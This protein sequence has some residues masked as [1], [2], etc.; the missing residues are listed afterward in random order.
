MKWQPIET[1]PKDGTEILVFGILR[2][3][4]RPDNA[5]LTI[6]KCLWEENRWNCPD[7]DDYYG[8]WYENVTHWRPLPPLPIE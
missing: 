5:A 6:G 8:T 1:A 2:R 4:V 7:T 3:E